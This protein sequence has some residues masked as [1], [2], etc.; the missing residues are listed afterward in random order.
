MEFRLQL[1]WFNKIKYS[2]NQLLLGVTSDNIRHWCHIHNYTD[3]D[4]LGNRIH[5]NGILKE[6]AGI[7]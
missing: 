7:I 3:I 5:T 4:F 2:L 6:G 1:K